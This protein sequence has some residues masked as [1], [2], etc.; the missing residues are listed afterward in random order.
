MASSWKRG[1]FR[2]HIRKNSLCCEG[3]ETLE[4]RS[5]EYPIPGSVQ[6]WSSEQCGLIEGV[7]ARGRGTGSRWFLRSFP[8]QDI[9]WFYD[10]VI[11]F[12]RVA[13]QGTTSTV[14]QLAPWADY[15]YLGY[16]CHSINIAQLLNN[17]G[18]LNKI[19]GWKTIWSLRPGAAAEI[20]RSLYSP[21]LPG[22]NVHCLEV[23]YVTLPELG[24]WLPKAE[25]F[26]G[27]FSCS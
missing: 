25:S 23:G 17:T 26:N 27:T 12:V 10:S 9:L 20:Q 13:H 2:L 16:I 19:A 6:K 22:N 5:C 15:Q 3:G 21:I 11:F 14:C 1:M 7:L 18:K 8:S 4:Q 24:I